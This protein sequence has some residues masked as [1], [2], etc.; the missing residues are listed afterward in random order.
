MINLFRYGNVLARSKT[1]TKLQKFHNLLPSLWNGR[2]PASQPATT[3]IAEPF[4]AVLNI[5]SL[6]CYTHVVHDPR[7][8][9]QRRRYAK[10]SDWSASVLSS[11]RWG[12]ALKGAK[13]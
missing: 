3:T 6:L 12:L 10:I 9:Q 13:R 1:I 4:A 5:S 7:R 11:S 2:Q 8:H